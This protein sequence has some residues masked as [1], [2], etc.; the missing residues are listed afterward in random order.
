MHEPALHQRLDLA[1]GLE[2]GHESHLAL[3]R[4]RL[5]ADAPQRIEVHLDHVPARREREKVREAAAPRTRR[6]RPPCGATL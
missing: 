4:L 5:H 1:L 2:P 3:R 6:A